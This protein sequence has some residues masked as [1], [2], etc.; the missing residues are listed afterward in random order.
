M[1]METLSGLMICKCLLAS[2]REYSYTDFH[3]PH[4]GWLD[5]AKPFIA[6]YHAGAKTVDSYIT[7]DQLI[8]WY[9]PTL[10]GLDCD[11]TDTTM[12]SA[13]NASGNY[14]EGRPNGW[15]DMEDSVFVVALLTSAGTVTVTSGSNTQSF[16]APAGASAYQVGMQVGQQS[17][18]LKRGSD[19]VLSGTSLKDISSICICGIYNFNAYVG[20][21]PAGA[22]D[23]LGA[24]GLASLT[25]GLH[26]STCSATPSLGTAPSSPTSTPVTTTSSGGSAP[27]TSTSVPVTTASTTTTPTAPTTST[28]TAGTAPTGTCNAGTGPGNYLGLCNF[29]CNYGY[30]PAPC[31]CTSTGDAVSAPPTT[32]TAGYPLPGEDDSY[33]GLCSFT[34]NH[35]YCPSTACTTT[36]P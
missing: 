2:T 35:G 32:G 5:M 8:Y 30:C 9:R 4:D 20:S 18:S 33:L 19:T 6:A 21:L 34:C 14:F 17:F 13:N 3:R 27:T 29:S 24:D 36:A 15:E 7:D 16:D 12:V 23:P 11:A 28:T 31:T 10:R 22:S 1:M 26:V 25:A